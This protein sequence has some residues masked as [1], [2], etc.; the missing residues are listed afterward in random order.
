MTARKKKQQQIRI[1][2][3]RSQIG[4]QERQKRVLAGLGL[5]R[6]GQSVVRPDVPSIRG[7]VNKVPHLLSVEEVEG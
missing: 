7:M 2:Q 3:V 4:A 6:I 5:R 1:T